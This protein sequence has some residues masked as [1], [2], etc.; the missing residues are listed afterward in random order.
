MLSWTA[1][2][3]IWNLVE[4]YAGKRAAVREAGAVRAVVAALNM[5]RGSVNVQQTGL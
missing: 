5:H 4:G 3:A 1:A 2:G